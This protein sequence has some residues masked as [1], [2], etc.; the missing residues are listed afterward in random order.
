M[1]DLHDAERIRRRYPR[2]RSGRVVLVAL[3]S[4]LVLA[5]LTWLVWAAWEAAHPD[6]AGQVAGFTVRSDTSVEVNL[7]VERADPARAATCDVYV[8]SESY[9]R[10]GELTVDVPPGDQSQVRFD[11]TVKTFKRGTSASLGDCRTV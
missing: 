2:P 1:S 11:V 9:E 5:G 3:S 4:L 10:V 8:Q 7:I 6:V